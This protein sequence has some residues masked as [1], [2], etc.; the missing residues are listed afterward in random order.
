MYICDNWVST[1]TIHCSLF[2]SYIF[3]CMF[4]WSIW[5]LRPEG[6]ELVLGQRVCQL[7]AILSVLSTNLFDEWKLTGF[8]IHLNLGSQYASRGCENSM[9]N[10]G[11]ILYSNC[12]DLGFIAVRQYHAWGDVDEWWS[13]PYLKGMWQGMT[14]GYSKRWDLGS[15]CLTSIKIWDQGQKWCSLRKT[16]RWSIR[17][18]KWRLLQ[19]SST[20]PSG[21][22]SQLWNV[23]APGILMCQI[24]K[25]KLVN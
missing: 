14:Q 25:M 6:G 20:A 11:G 8:S 24:L 1:G 21:A 3:L 7:L 4:P 2:Q 16:M 19:R 22:V 13:G 15:S 10:P 12:V 5:V 17:V 23:P 9:D 18:I